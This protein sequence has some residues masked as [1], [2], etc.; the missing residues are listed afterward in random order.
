MLETLEDPV[1]QDSKDHRDHRGL[2]SNLPKVCPD[3]EV[4]KENQETWEHQDLMGTLER[5]DLWDTGALPA[6]LEH[7]ESWG[8]PGLVVSPSRGNREKTAFPVCP[9]TGDLRD[10]RGLRVPLERRVNRVSLSWDLL[11]TT[12][13]PGETEDPGCREYAETPENLAR[14][15]LP[16]EACGR[17]AQSVP[18]AFRESREILAR[19]DVP[20]GTDRMATPGPEETTAAPVPPE[21]PERAA[22]EGR[23]ADQVRKA[24]RDSLEVWAHQETRENLVT[25]ESQVSEASLEFLDQTASTV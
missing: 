3:R 19:L 12:E 4:L 8:N 7:P 25:R 17:W 5:P 2:I 1:A 24:H 16:V 15:E 18:W 13:G 9:E 11:E 21:F 22:T 10:L 23:T 6:S 14:K 20:E